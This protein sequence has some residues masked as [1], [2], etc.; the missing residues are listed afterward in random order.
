MSA[1]LAPIPRSL[2]ALL[3]TG[4]GVAALAAGLLVAR[5]AAAEGDADFLLPVAG[6]LL[7]SIALAVVPLLGPPLVTPPRWGLVVLGVTATRTLVAMGAMLILLEILGL[8]RRPVVYGLLSGTLLLLV[9]DAIGAV[10]LL[11]RRDAARI[12]AAPSPDSSRSHA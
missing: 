11:S 3:M 6:S 7:F 10:W 5:A 12:P 4:A 1:D 2:Y 8:P 9:A